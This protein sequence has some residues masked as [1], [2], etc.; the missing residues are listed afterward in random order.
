MAAEFDCSSGGRALAT[1]VIVLRNTTNQTRPDHS[2]VVIEVLVW[3]KVLF[4]SWQRL[5]A[6]AEPRVWMATMAVAITLLFV[7]WPLRQ[8]GIYD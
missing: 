2:F 3:E 6:G 7:L 5:V 4:T 1:V 8:T